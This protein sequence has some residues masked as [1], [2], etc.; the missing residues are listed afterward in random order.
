M[1]FERDISRYHDFLIVMGEFKQQ[2]RNITDVIENVR[3]LFMDDRM[4]I[5]E[6]NNFLPAQFRIDTTNFPDVH[7]VPS[8]SKGELVYTPHFKLPNGMV[9]DVNP[10]HGTD[11]YRKAKFPVKTSPATPLPTG[12]A[13]SSI[14]GVTIGSISK[15]KNNTRIVPAGKTLAQTVPVTVENKPIKSGKIEGSAMKVLQAGGN[16]HLVSE[17]SP[18]PGAV[19]PMVRSLQF[20]GYVAAPTNLPST[21]SGFSPA[22]FVQQPLAGGRIGGGASTLIG[23]KRKMSDGSIAKLNSA[24][25]VNSISAAVNNQPASKGERPKAKR[26]KQIHSDAGSSGA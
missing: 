11:N 17:R 16:S 15:D 8:I 12:G 19:N 26:P 2:I 10:N 24:D 6:F 20:R 7:Y 23:T 13:G 4:L 5:S 18:M 21:V 22:P 3:D 14:G 1:R 25:A 9:V